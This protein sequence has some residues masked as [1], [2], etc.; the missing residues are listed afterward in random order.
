MVQKKALKHWDVNVDKIVVSKLIK[1]KTNSKYLTGYLDKV[2]R[3][4]VLILRKMNGYA[5]I[6]NGKDGNKDKSNKL[7]SFRIDDVKLLEKNKTF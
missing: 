7:M 5:E 4:E 6:F 2:L 1:I 3:S